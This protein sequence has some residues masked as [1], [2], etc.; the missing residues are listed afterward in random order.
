MDTKEKIIEIDNAPPDYHKGDSV[1]VSIS[2]KHGYKALFI[3]YLLPF[4]LSLTTLIICI[5]LT[6][7]EGLSGLISVLILAPYF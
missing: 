3:A 7:N 5:K 2:G 6:G 4:L 1:V